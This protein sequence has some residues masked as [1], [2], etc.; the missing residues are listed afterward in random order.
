MDKRKTVAVAELARRNGGVAVVQ[1]G[2]TA[3][4]TSEME[5]LLGFMAGH[6]CA[7]C[8]RAVDDVVWLESLYLLKDPR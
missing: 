6:N 3:L 2:S 8:K 5:S 7:K 1:L 4:S